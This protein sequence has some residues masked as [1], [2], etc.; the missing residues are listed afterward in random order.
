MKNL[1]TIS[2][3]VLMA[4]VAPLGAFAQSSITVTTE[5]DTQLGNIAFYLFDDAG[6][7]LEDDQ[8]IPYQV[9]YRNLQVHA[10]LT[11]SSA[12]LKSYSVTFE[13]VPAGRY[14]VFVNHDLNGNYDIDFKPD[15][16]PIE[17]LGFSNN[18]LP[19]Q[20]NWDFDQISF[21][22]ADG[23]NVEIRVD[24]NTL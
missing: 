2:T 10:R 12:N 16:T 17:P 18:P 5:V 1:A 8:E 6:W 15:W 14:G 19:E 22:V 7:T 20:V 24:L 13:D 11:E 9:L 23:E 3:L 21:D 4:F